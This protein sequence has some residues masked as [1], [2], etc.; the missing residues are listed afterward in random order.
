VGGRPAYVH[1][2]HTAVSSLVYFGGIVTNIYNASLHLYVITQ[3]CDACG[4]LLFVVVSRN[5][6]A[7]IQT[8]FVIKLDLF[9][10]YYLCF[11]I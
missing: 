3:T 11:I 5:W 6:I 7:K 1:V 4:R 8:L 9:L 10:D 2:G